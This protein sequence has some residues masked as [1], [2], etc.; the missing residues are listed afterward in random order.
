MHEDIGNLADDND[1]LQTHNPS[2]DSV[3]V[4][5]AVDPNKSVADLKDADGTVSTL[6]RLVG[7]VQYSSDLPIADAARF[8]FESER[9]YAKR[10]SNQNGLD[11]SPS[12]IAQ[13][14]IIE[15]A[16]GTHCFSC[17]SS[18]SDTSQLLNIYPNVAIP[19]LP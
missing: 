16:R 9:D 8:S 3:T 4:G 18:H 15:S 5:Q 13:A 6:H 17:F 7:S 19:F 10:L 14:S 2:R 1:D 11:I 12:R